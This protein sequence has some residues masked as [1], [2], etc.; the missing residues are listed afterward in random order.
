MIRALEIAFLVVITVATSRAG[1]LTFGSATR[2]PGPCADAAAAATADALAKRFDDHQ[3]I[4][5]GSTHGDLKI[6]EFLMCL[7]SRPA[8]TRRATD[9]V[10]EWASFGHQGLIDRYILNLDAIHVDNLAPIWFDTDTPTLWTT[11]P[12][13]HEF[14][15]TLREVNR[16]L[17]AM[18][19][20]RLVSGNEGID[21]SKVRAAEDLAPYPYKTNLVPH[22]IVEHLAKSPGNRTLVVYGD[23][24]IHY[25][26]NN[27]MGDL[28]AALGRAKLFVVGRIGELVPA[29]RTFLAAVGNPEQA[30]FVAADRFPANMD[31]PRSLRVCAGESSPRLADYIDAFV[32]LGPTPDR[33]LVGSIPLTAAQQRELDRR[34]SIKADAQ[35]TMRARYQGRDT[36]FRAHPNDFPPRPPL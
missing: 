20:I 23:C 34:S 15:D 6:E 9:I 18:K 36:W 13:V 1:T 29:E 27:F 10:A 21:W 3:F 11:L 30:F 26:G 31:G 4:F 22:L 17:P 28:E 32:Y 25:K 19:R 7:V 16:T 33:S 8:F 24:H 12:Q 14:V 35:R 2:V 5:I